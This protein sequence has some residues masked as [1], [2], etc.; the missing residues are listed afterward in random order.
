MKRNLAA[1]DMCWR[2]A[3][4]R[5]LGRAHTLERTVTQC[6]SSCQPPRMMLWRQTL[7]DQCLQGKVK[8]EVCSGFR[9]TN[10]GRV[11]DRLCAG[12]YVKDSDEGRALGRDWRKDSTREV[13]DRETVR[14]CRTATGDFDAWTAPVL[15]QIQ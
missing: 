5:A 15:S 6:V 9:R 12:N 8:G 3:V 11:A 2:N 13:F 7:R 4:A 1:R 14:Q 10:G